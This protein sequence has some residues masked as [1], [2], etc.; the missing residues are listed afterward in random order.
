MLDIEKLT[1]IST[2]YDLTYEEI[3]YLH[4]LFHK[5]WKNLYQYE[6]LTEDPKENRVNERQE[7]PKYLE[8]ID[9]GLVNI[10]NQ[11]GLPIQ[12]A[13]ISSGRR[14][15]GITSS[16]ILNLINRKIIYRLSGRTIHEL[17]AYELTDE[18]YN[19]FYIDFEQIFEDLKKAY[20][21]EVD[22][23]GKIY[24]IN[25]LEEKDC[26]LYLKLIRNNVDK[27]KEIIAKIESNQDKLNYKIDRFI[28]TK[29]WEGLSVENT[30]KIEK[31]ES[32]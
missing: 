10:T 27:H 9:K 22:V 5:D 32:I 23:N 12:Q 15:K 26:K 7:N 25:L 29:A 4:I 13:K 17:D 20:P 14:R 24:P 30:N 2:K 11:V 1:D 19:L 8:A 16:D 18:Y 21:K 6:N 31:I 28:A 3:C